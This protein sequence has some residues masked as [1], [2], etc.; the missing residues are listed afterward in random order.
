MEFIRKSANSVYRAKVEGRDVVL[1]I[2][3]SPLRRA[4]K[5]ESE[6][7][8]IR[9]LGE[10]GLEVAAPLES[11]HSKWVESFEVDA[12]KYHCSV[13]EFVPGVHPGPESFNDVFLFNWGRYLSKLHR[14]SQKWS[15]SG[16]GDWNQDA[17]F[18]SAWRGRLLG[19]S[20]LRG[21][22]ETDVLWLETLPKT[23]QTYGW[24]HADLHTGNLLVADGK[25]TAIDFED[26]CK[27]WLAFDLTAPLHSFRK[28]YG[29]TL[30]A[31]AA[32]NT[33]L[34]GYRSEHRTPESVFFQIENFYRF[35]IAQVY[36]WLLDQNSCG[37]FDASKQD[38]VQ[39]GLEYFKLELQKARST[40]G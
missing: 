27:H 31:K 9:Y 10:R 23:A 7:A 25:I 39:K 35:R 16:R 28:F 29:H 21:L 37:A 6:L 36:F 5:L 24:V 19:E 3:Q 26:C 1:R 13:F 30:Q 8:W 20:A 12:E 34:R 15:D 17:V 32:M 4:L 22:F 2:S 40:D 14:L 18:I 38:W 33:L 11:C